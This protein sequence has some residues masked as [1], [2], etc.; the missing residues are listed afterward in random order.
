[1]GVCQQMYEFDDHERCYP[2]NMMNGI[3]NVA[4]KLV[5]EI[6]SGKTSLE[7]LNIEQIGQ[8]VLSGVNPEEM[9]QFA[10]N[11]DKILPAIGQF[12]MLKK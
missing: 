9:T 8:Q 7:N 6:A 11:M 12:G 3:E 2:L 1:M 10:N 5:S 4:N